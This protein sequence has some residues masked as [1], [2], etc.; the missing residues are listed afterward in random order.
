MSASQ[1]E[2]FFLDSD[3]GLYASYTYL[4]PEYVP[5]QHVSHQISVY[6]SSWTLCQVQEWVTR[7]CVQTMGGFWIFNFTGVKWVLLC[8]DEFHLKTTT[9]NNA[10]DKL[11]YI[12]SAITLILRT[13]H[14]I[15]GSGK[16]LC[17]IKDRPWLPFS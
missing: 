15:K 16:C 6:V 11:E 2:V 12:Y 17:F 10:M 4:D 8:M 5:E 7:R 9:L 1:N 14:R 13:C 3:P